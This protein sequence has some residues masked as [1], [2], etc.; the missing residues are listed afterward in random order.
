MST[1]PQAINVEV[2]HHIEWHVFGL[3]WNVDTI[4][5]TL[6]AGSIVLG[7]GFYMRAHVSVRKPGA[8]QLFWETVTK[9]MGTR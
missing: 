3:V 9:W 1:S 5:A 6:I 2:G 8:I 4:L 7:L